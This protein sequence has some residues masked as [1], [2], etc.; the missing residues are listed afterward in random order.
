MSVEERHSVSLGYETVINLSLDWTAIRNQL[1]TAGTN[2][3]YLS[4]GRAEWVTFDWPA[5]PELVAGTGK[6]YLDKAIAATKPADGSERNVALMID[7]F[8]PEWIKKT[9][10]LAGVRING[11]R[12]TYTPSVSAVLNGPVGDR[13]VELAVELTRRYHPYM[14]TFTELLF[15]ATFGADDFALFK[16]MTGRADWPRTSTGSIDTSFSSPISQWRSDA[17]AQFLARVRAEMNAVDPEVKLGMDVSTHWN[18]ISADRQDV[19][20]SYRTLAP[21]VDRLIIWAYFGMTSR[22]P[23]FLAQKTDWIN[24]LVLPVPVTMSV[25]LWAGED[26][27]ETLGVED[28]AYGVLASETHGVTSINVTPY[29]RLTSGHWSALNDVW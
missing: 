21:S 17:M 28:M 1:D 22:D 8:I 5:H 15:D 18:K 14:V 7:A 29:S 25:G 13:Y 4:A 24:K 16:Q 19:G 27:S 9:P 2:T 11:T 23:R 3:V 6:K 20:H 10:S 12:N 26:E